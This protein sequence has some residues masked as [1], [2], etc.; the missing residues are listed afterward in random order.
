ML[1]S[2]QMAHFY[3][4]TG[5]MFDKS[6]FG[7]APELLIF[8]WSLLAP[9]S[10]SSSLFAL[11]VSP[12]SLAAVLGVPLVVVRPVAHVT[13]PGAGVE[14]RVRHCRRRSFGGCFTRPRRIRTD[15]PLSPILLL[16]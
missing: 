6:L 2:T 16:K 3:F 11:I 5:G 4:F 15:S 13:D 9:S 1:E 12:P 8:F 7:I 10:V 14:H